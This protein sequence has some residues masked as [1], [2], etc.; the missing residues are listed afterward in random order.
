MIAVACGKEDDT[1]PKNEPQRNV[2]NQDTIK[3]ADTVEIVNT[4]TTNI[5]NTDTTNIINTDT[6]SDINKRDGIYS[7]ELY[8]FMESQT[9]TAV[10]YD[11]KILDEIPNFDTMKTALHKFW[12]IKINL[13]LTECI[14]LKDIPEYAFSSNGSCCYNLISIT[15][16]ESITN[17]GTHAFSDCYGLTSVIIP[18]GVTNIGDW[19][20]KSC[21]SLS[22]VVLSKGLTNIGFGAFSYS[23]ITTITIPDGVTS[24]AN[25]VFNDCTRLIEVTIPPS[26][27]CMDMDFYGCINLKTINHSL[28]E[29]NYFDFRGCSNLTSITIPKSTETPCFRDFTNLTSAVFAEG[30]TKI[31]EN[32]FRNCQNLTSVSIPESVT[33][34]GENAFSNCSSLTSIT[35]P[36]GITRIEECTFENCSSL[37]S[38]LLPE[39]L[40]NIGLVAFG[41]CSGLTSISFP[42]SVISV[43]A[44]A[45]A[46]CS[47]LT[48]IV[49]LP[50]EGDEIWFSGLGCTSLSLITIPQNVRYISHLDCSDNQNLTTVKIECTEPPVISYNENGYEISFCNT[51]T[52]YVPESAIEK[53]KTAKGWKEF[54]DQIVG[55]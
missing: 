52:I 45:F 38:I 26:V 44:L 10:V 13:N 29:S 33:S 31:C 39:G 11:V 50:Y 27:E 46:G 30:T 23:G 4:D 7:Y 48:S 47:S 41:G 25:R 1:T 43:S 9:D 54:A 20:F 14:G 6:V 19:A 42:N 51:P 18:E 37:T 24:I 55:Y 35:I 3:N 21:K 8:T 40:T 32:C 15:F 49:V 22:S 16:P 2:E 53:Y 5:V 36:Q 28:K 17:I 12:K 34:I